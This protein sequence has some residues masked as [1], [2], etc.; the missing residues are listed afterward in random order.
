MQQYKYKTWEISNDVL[1]IKQ[2][3]KFSATQITGFDRQHKPG[4]VTA[5]Q[6]DGQQKH[7]QKYVPEGF[8]PSASHTSVK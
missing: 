6:F 2:Q 7:N 5:T 3:D 8:Y 4:K 1:T